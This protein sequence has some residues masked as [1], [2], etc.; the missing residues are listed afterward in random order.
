MCMM[1]GVEVYIL[2]LE[3][4]LVSLYVFIPTIIGQHVDVQL[5]IVLTILS[6][7]L[8]ILVT[9]MYMQLNDTISNYNLWRL[10]FLTLK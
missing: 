7:S 1:H 4:A 2:F 8:R 3:S 10:H 5:E 9:V 6:A